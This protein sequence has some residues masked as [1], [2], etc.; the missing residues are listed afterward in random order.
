MEFLQFFFSLLCQ[1]KKDSNSMPEE[2]E[3]LQ[4]NLE[5]TNVLDNRCTLI[6]MPH[7]IEQIAVSSLSLKV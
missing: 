3:F 1:G 2:A 6:Q 7:V 4:T 5:N